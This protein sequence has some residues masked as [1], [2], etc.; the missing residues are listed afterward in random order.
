MQVEVGD[1]E[2]KVALASRVRLQETFTKDVI[3]TT[4]CQVMM[5]MMKCLND[6]DDDDEF[7]KKKT[8]FRCMLSSNLISLSSSLHISYI[9]F[10]PFPEYRDI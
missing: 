1:Q 7:P 4:K 5:M 6:Y 3:E 9:Y 10:F 8:R 2:E